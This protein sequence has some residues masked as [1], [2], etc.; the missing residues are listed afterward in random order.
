M[1]LELP[2]DQ[3]PRCS[4]PCAGGSLPPVFIGRGLLSSQGEPWATAT[5]QMQG[6]PQTRTCWQSS[7]RSEVGGWGAWVA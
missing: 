1:Y 2:T 7:T 4:G 5:P 6:L 3:G